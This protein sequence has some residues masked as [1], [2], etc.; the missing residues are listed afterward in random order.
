MRRY[1]A[2]G[3]VSASEDGHGGRYVDA[4]ELLRVGLLRQ[5]PGTDRSDGGNAAPEPQ[6]EAARLSE[7]LATAEARCRELE[8]DR[9]LWRQQAAAWQEQ[10]RSLLLALS[11]APEPT[12]ESP[13]PKRRWP[14]GRR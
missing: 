5:S 9:D 14:W 13:K 3:K 7:R 11:A 12:P 10:A 4:D 2:G 6:A 1:V 8:T